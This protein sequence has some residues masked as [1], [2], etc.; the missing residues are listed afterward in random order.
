MSWF[1]KESLSEK[2][3]DLKKLHDQGFLSD[4]DFSSRFALLNKDKEDSHTLKDWLVSLFI[5]A[6]ENISNEQDRLD[7]LTWLTLAREKLADN[8][9]SS[10]DKFTQIYALIDFKKSITAV[11]SGVSEAVKN[12]ARSDLPLAL[13]ITLPVTL[14]A[15]TVIGGQ[16][17]G[18]AGFGSAIGL[19]VLLLIFVGVAG[20]TSILQAFL[21]GDDT[22]NYIGVVLSM[23]ARDEVLRRTKQS[24]REAMSAAPVAPKKQ[25]LSSEIETLKANLLEMNPYDFERHVMSFF[26][27]KGLLAWVT[28]KNND[29]GVDGFARHENGLIIVQCKRNAINNTVGRPVI[30]QFKGVIEENEAWCGYVVTTSSFTKEA[31]ESSL[32]NNRVVLIAMD[33]LV[34]WHLNGVQYPIFL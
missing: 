15:A 10:L 13:K 22:D 33:E 30:Q 17:V 18:V 20:V 2:I 29:A 23:I 16:S 21:G 14:A 31:L 19:P 34:V 28:K 32:K 1:T 24:L 12:Y 25:V 6:L 5:K 27:D 11:F 3:D 4:E 7:I 8:S 9:L 26:Q